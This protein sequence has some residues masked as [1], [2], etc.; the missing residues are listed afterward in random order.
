MK[1]APGALGRVLN[2][3]RIMVGCSQSLNGLEAA[4]LGSAAGSVRLQPECPCWS[5][6]LSPDRIC[7][8]G[9]AVPAPVEVTREPEVE[10]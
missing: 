4:R 7:P 5:N 3:S 9:R 10:E 6:T 2:T 1:T 8:L